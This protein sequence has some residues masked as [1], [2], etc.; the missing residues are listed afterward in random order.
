MGIELMGVRK[1]GERLEG[2]LGCGFAII[3]FAFGLLQLAAGWAGIE[4][5]YGW[6]WGVAAVVAAIFFR[7]TIPIAF[8]AFLCAKNIWEWHWLFALIFALP[9]LLFMIPAFLGSLIDAAKR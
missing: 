5:S 3:F 2:T 9:G 6:G 7:F 8:G 1:M 4:D